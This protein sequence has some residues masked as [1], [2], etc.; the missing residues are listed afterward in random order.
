M[1]PLCPTT[2]PL[3]SWNFLPSYSDIPPTPDA[4]KVAFPSLPS[5]PV[6]PPSET[7]AERRASAGK[8]PNKALLSLMQM[9]F[10]AS[11]DAGMGLGVGPSSAGFDGMEDAGLAQAGKVFQLAMSSDKRDEDTHEKQRETVTSPLLAAPGIENEGGR[12]LRRSGSTGSLRPNR[13]RSPLRSTRPYSFHATDSPSRSPSSPCPA[14]PLVKRS[15]AFAST[16]TGPLTPLTPSHIPGAPSLSNSSSAFEWFSYSIP[17]SPGFPLRPVSPAPPQF[18]SS[19]LTLP[20]T[21]T[22]DSG[23]ITP[24]GRTHFSSHKSSKIPSSPLG[25]GRFSE[26][27]TKLPSSNPFFA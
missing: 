10:E 7:L 3:S 2:Q 25:R 18:D 19:S 11:D 14:S 6:S 4:V 9:K 1:D 27:Q 12:T 21:P 15:S 17:D 22:S 8:L 5:P 16:N 13:S 26:E 24:T 23:S 20:L